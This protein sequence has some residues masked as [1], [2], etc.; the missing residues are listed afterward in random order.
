ME[1]GTVKV[2]FHEFAPLMATS[3]GWS[4]AGPWR[5]MGA[6]DIAEARGIISSNLSQ[7]GRIECRRVHMVL[8]CVG[9]PDGTSSR[10][11]GGAPGEGVS[12]G[13]HG[14]DH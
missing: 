14:L 1:L 5:K 2:F 8:V 12:L 4:Y 3:N 13:L 10:V 6:R 9:E 11:H 7:V